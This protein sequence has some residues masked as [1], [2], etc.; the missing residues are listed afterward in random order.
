MKT[1]NMDLLE[2]LSRKP[3]HR[4]NKRVLGQSIDERPASVE[5]RSTFGHWEID[6]VVG[7]KAKE[8]AV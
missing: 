6:T 7:N 8:D 4:Q 3:K 5:D 1:T 2:K